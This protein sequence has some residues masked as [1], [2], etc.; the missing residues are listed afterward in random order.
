MSGDIPIQE[1][2]SDEM[3]DNRSNEDGG[4]TVEDLSNM[5]NLVGGSGP[6]SGTSGGGVPIMTGVG[7]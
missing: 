4:A 1:K 2:P 6:A 3:S 5:H 7:T